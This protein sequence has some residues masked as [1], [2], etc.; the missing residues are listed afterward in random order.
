[1]ARS[2]E[3]ENLMKMIYQMSLQNDFSE[4]SYEKFT[5][6]QVEI[7]ITKY[8]SKTYELIRENLADIDS[9]IN[10]C[11]VKWKTTRMPAVD[12][13]ILRLAVAEM[14]F[15]KDIP[16]SVSINEAVNLAKAYS[17]ENSSRF[18]NGVLGK[19]A[20]EIENAQA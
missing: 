9:F 1:M 16:V 14:K 12:L 8:F 20:K 10:E 5:E 6:L 4:E 17:T 18:I 13:A 3:R 15:A 19:V 7:N 2:E 11:S